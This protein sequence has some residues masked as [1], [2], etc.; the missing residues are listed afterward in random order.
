MGVKVREKITG[1]GVWWVFVNH[2]GMRKSK[3][4]GTE[5]LANK[6]KKEGLNGQH[7]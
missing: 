3:K 4:V 7:L 5:K 2:N 6:T 1:S